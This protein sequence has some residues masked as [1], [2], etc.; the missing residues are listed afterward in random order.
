[1]QPALVWAGS[2]QKHTEMSDEMATRKRVSGGLVESVAPSS[3][4]ITKAEIIAIRDAALLAEERVKHGKLPRPRDRKKR[5]RVDPRIG[6]YRSNS[7]RIEEFELALLQHGINFEELEK[8]AISYQR[9]TRTPL[10]KLAHAVMEWWCSASISHIRVVFVDPASGYTERNMPKLSSM[11][12]MQLV[13]RGLAGGVWV[14]TRKQLLEARKWKKRM[15]SL[16]PAERLREPMVFG[17][18]RLAHEE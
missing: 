3:G 4:I 13:A 17:D 15:I 5:E 11:E 16:T 9:G 8:H 14:S 6:R 2:E 7:D 12:G 10:A 18:E 1:M